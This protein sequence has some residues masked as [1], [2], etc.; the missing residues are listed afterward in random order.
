MFGM[1]AH[2]VGTA[3]ARELGEVEGSV[4]G[5]TMVLAGLVSVLAAPLLAVCL[6]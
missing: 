2:G 6:R 5:L 4:A 3:K 1:G